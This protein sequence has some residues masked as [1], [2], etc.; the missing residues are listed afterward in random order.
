LTC[1]IPELI[2]KTQEKRIEGA[3]MINIIRN[4][5]VNYLPADL[6]TSIDFSRRS[7]RKLGAKLTVREPSGFEVAA[8]R[9]TNVEQNE[10]L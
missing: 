6:V 3:A 1:R 8:R 9:K 7:K 2:D 5:K 10:I 4:I